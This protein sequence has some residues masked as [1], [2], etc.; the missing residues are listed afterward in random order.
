[1][2]PWNRLPKELQVKVLRNLTR[3]DLDKCR[4][5]NR[6]TFQL[7]RHNEKSMKRR[8]IDK[9]ATIRYLRVC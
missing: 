9:N 3:S 2:F 8:I 7:I 5:L 4:V 6:K 1:Y